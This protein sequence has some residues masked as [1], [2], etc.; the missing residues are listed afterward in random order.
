VSLDLLASTLHL[1]VALA[2]PIALAALGECIVE[3]AGNLNLGIEGMMLAGAFC[4][5]V[6]GIATGSPVVAI[7]AGVAGGAC[8]ALLLAL[9]VLRLRLD[10]V[11]AGMALNLLAFGGTAVLWRA[12]PGSSSVAPEVPLLPELAVPLLADLPVLGPALFHHQPLVLLC[13]VLPPLLWF[14]LFRTGP[15]LVLRAAGENPEAARAAGIRVDRVR[16]LALLCGGALAGAG[17][18]LLL[19]DA[20]TFGEGMTSGRGFVALAIVIFGAHSPVW[21]LAAAL[22]VGGASALQSVLQAMRLD[23]PPDVKRLLPA[24][25]RSLPYVLSL[26]VLAGFAGRRRP[27]AGIGRD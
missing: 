3:R 9:L 12:R 11:V 6:A 20:A 19:T 13:F 15:G 27:P 2:A 4:G 18:S 1:G 23:V 7:A 5:A 17:G 25:F 24:V 26:L 8:L 14:F 22:L 21:T 16:L 10:Q